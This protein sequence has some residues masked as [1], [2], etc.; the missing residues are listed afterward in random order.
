MPFPLRRDVKGNF[1][2]VL[3]GD[4]KLA[5]NVLAYQYG[6]GVLIFTP[7]IGA[8]MAILAIAGVRYSQWLLFA[9]PFCL[10]LFALMLLAIRVAV[11]IGL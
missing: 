1:I 7:T 5:Y 2:D 4:D 6:N 3:R 11:A 8:L 10:A 9:V